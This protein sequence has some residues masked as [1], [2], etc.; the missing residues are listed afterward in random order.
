MSCIAASLS[1]SEPLTHS[2][3]DSDDRLVSKNVLMRSTAL[4]KTPNCVLAM[5]SPNTSTAVF[6]SE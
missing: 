3:S 4:F 6:T 5:T 1:A 2:S